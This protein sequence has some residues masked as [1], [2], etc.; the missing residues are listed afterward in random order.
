M[1]IWN[2][3]KKAADG[4]AVTMLAAMFIIFCAQIFSRYALNEP[5][6]WSEELCLTLWLWLIFWTGAFCLKS[7]DHIRFDILYLSAPKK[8]QR[9]MFFLAALGIIV[10]FGISLA[11]TWD[12][13]TFY[14]IKKSAILKIR[15]DYVFSIYGVFLAVIIIRYSWAV[16][17]L[18]NPK[19]KEEQEKSRL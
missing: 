3:L 6:G 17:T 9:A 7:S 11:P 1:T 10:G 2:W 14:K 8:I 12:Y 15:L 5:L 4:I 13:I 18:I 19:R 16:Y